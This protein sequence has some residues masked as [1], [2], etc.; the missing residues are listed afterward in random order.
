MKTEAETGG[1]RLEAKE[2]QG[3][4]QKLQDSVEPP[5]GTHL[6]DD[7][8]SDAWLPELLES[9]FLLIEPSRE[10]A[11]GQETPSTQQDTLGAPERLRAQCGSGLGKAEIGFVPL[12]F[13]LLSPFHEVPKPQD[14][15]PLLLFTP[16]GDL[17]GRGHIQ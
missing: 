13:P 8:I 2:P 14:L 3:Q 10:G 15:A 5:E 7:L 6:V 9:R 4:H 16:P 12:L 11:W 17:K 1:T